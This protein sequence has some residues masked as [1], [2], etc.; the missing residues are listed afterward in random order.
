[1]LLNIFELVWCHGEETVNIY[2]VTE[3]LSQQRVLGAVVWWC[4]CWVLLV[5]LISCC[6]VVG[7]EEGGW[8][9]NTTTVELNR[10]WGCRSKSVEVWHSTSEHA[11]PE[12]VVLHCHSTILLWYHC[13]CFYI[14]IPHQTVN[15]QIKLSFPLYLLSMSVKCQIQRSISRKKIFVFSSPQVTHLLLLQWGICREIGVNI[16]R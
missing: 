12:C 2:L 11:W 5:W 9:A 4:C 16:L 8:W 3:D 13:H 15:N 14:I 10:F 7:R 6:C 1:M